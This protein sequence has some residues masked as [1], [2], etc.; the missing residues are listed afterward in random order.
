[1]CEKLV[2]FH[3]LLLDKKKLCLYVF[4][5]SATTNNKQQT[6]DNKQQTILNT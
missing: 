1:M 4:K 5:F 2:S 3:T 6:T